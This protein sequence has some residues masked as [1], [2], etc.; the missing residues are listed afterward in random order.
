MLST[1]SGAQPNTAWTVD[2]DFNVG[3]SWQNNV[4]FEH[5][6][7]DRYSVSIGASYV[8]GYNLPIVTNVN[9]I[10]AVSTL[11]TASRVPDS[12]QRDHPRHPATT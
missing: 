5:A 9:L 7:S 4:Q 8:K 2:P 11:P 3:R 10:N 12:R 6:L 1:G